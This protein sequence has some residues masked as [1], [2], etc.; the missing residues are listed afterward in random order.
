MY[1]SQREANLLGPAKPDSEKDAD[2]ENGEEDEGKKDADEKDGE[3][4]VADAKDNDE[5]EESK[6]PPLKQPDEN[7]RPKIDPQLNAALL[8]MRIAVFGDSY[9]TLAAA[10]GLEEDKIGKP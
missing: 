4:K 10:A 2:D 7:N 6:L 5:D 1:C 3:D 8:Y 9:P